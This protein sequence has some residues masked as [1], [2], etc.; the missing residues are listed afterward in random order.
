MH[1]GKRSSCSTITWAAG[2]VGRDD[3]DSWELFGVGVGSH[4]NGPVMVIAPDWHDDATAHL[5]IISA[6]FGAL[7]GAIA[8]LCQLG[9]ARSQGLIDLENA[10]ALTRARSGHPAF[11]PADALSPWPGCGSGAYILGIL[12]LCFVTGDHDAADRAAVVTRLRE[13]GFEDDDLRALAKDLGWGTSLLMAV[14]DNQRVAA[15]DDILNEV[16]VK[17]G[18]ASMNATVAD[19]IHQYGLRCPWRA[20]A[21]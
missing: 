7:D 19:L 13:A 9:D 3:R 4:P 8:A 21:S 12:S 6:T 1:T 15:V 14:I 2:Q 17:I 11:L 10:V 20:D 5:H 16:A 18:W